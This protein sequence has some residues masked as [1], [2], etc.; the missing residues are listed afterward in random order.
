[1]IFTSVRE[2]FYA[3]ENKKVKFYWE[4]SAAPGQSPACHTRVTL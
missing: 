1:M 4:G 2:Q 3:D